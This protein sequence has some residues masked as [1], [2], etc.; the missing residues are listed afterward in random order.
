MMNTLTVKDKIQEVEDGS[1]TSAKGYKAGGFHAGLRYNKKDLGIIVSDTVA[2]AAAVYTQSLVQAAPILVT[3]DSVS[4]SGKIQAMIVNSACANACTGEQGMLDAYEMRSETA[5]KLG[6]EPHLV[7]VASTG[8]IGEYMKMDKIKAGIQQIAFSD[9]KESV[10]DFQTAIMTTDTFTKSCAFS[11]EIAGKTVTVGGA[12]KGSGMIHP[13]MATMLGF[14]TTDANVSAEHL[15]Q[16]LTQSVDVTF[17]QITVD[18]DTS[19]NDMVIITANG[20]SGC[21]QITPDHADWSTFVALVAVTSEKLAKKIARDGEGATKLIEVTVE[22]AQSVQDARIIA[23]TVVGSSL[24]K[25]AVYGAD[26]NWGRIIA[27]MGRSGVTFNPNNVDI[28]LGDILLLQ[29]ST[30]VAF[31]EEEATAY[32]QNN[33]ICIKAVLKEGKEKGIAWGCDLTYDYVKINASYRT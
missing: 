13:N 1:V 19:T 6:I 17:N 14:L 10:N 30:P 11:A 8:V 2:N 21:E 18:G 31:S 4:H 9:T 27:A 32:L 5:K 23:K 33:T 16:A 28:Y 12:A 29:Q 22:G 25:T 24:V 20:A 3:K 15:H 7:A 26:A